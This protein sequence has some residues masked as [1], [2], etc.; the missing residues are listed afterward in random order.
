MAELILSWSRSFRANELTVED[1]QD[2]FVTLDMSKTDLPLTAQKRIVEAQRELDSILWGMCE[3]GQRAEVGRVFAE[4]ERIFARNDEVS[5]TCGGFRHLVRDYAKAR[6]EIHSTRHCH[7]GKLA[8]GWRK[9]L[10]SA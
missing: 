6:K 1:I 7:P 4:L 8:R 2:R 3:A 10:T 5:D 9:R